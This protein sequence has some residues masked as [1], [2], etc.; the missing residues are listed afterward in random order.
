[1]YHAAVATAGNI[2]FTITDYF[3]E[4]AGG[5]NGCTA[6]GFVTQQNQEKNTLPLSIPPSKPLPPEDEVAINALFEQALRMGPRDKLTLSAPND[7]Q[8]ATPLTP[9]TEEISKTTPPAPAL[10]TDCVDLI[11]GRTLTSSEKKYLRFVIGAIAEIESTVDE[12][13]L[14]YTL[15]VVCLWNFK[16]I[17]TILHPKNTPIAKVALDIN[18]MS[19]ITWNRDIYFRSDYYPRENQN[20]SL[21]GHEVFHSLQAESYRGNIPSL[22]LRLFAPSWQEIYIGESIR[23]GYRWNVFEKPA[24]ALQDTIDEITRNN[25]LRLGDQISVEEE[26]ARIKEQIQLIFLR[27]M[28][29]TP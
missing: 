26:T 28:K 8:N 15:D 10:A 1:L 7:M 2:T 24:Y 11:G 21:T 17:P 25:V 9:P 20:I 3:G 16:D 5:N 29:K 27:H 23:M 18:K 4:N 12:E 19:A 13:Y 14:E 22:L 6:Y